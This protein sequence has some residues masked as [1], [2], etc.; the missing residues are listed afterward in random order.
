M[1]PEESNDL[2][3]IRKDKGLSLSDV[4]N[5]LK[6]T[7]DMIKKLE[8]SEFKTLG[9]YPYIRGY[10]INYTQLL[11]VES[12]KYISLIPKSE[13]VSPLI[14]TGSSLTKGIKLRRQSKNM[15]SYTIGTSIVL[16]ISFSGWYLL[17]NYMG[18]TR[19]LDNNI[20]LVSEKNIQITPQGSLGSKETNNDDSESFHYSSLIPSN[21]LKKE[22]N[23]DL[24]SSLTEEVVN[25]DE[26]DIPI[27]KV[28]TEDSV[29]QDNT[30]VNRSYEIQISAEETSW[31]K[32]EHLDGNKI[33]NDLFKP[34][35]M[36]FESDQPVHFRIGNRSKVQVTINGEAV[37]LSQYSSK[38]IADF[39]WPQDS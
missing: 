11:G 1:N 37:N 17:K 15:A 27:Q 31:V 28:V 26:I 38:N 30:V 5:K 2:K 7:S 39:K 16:I 4:A 12:E 10:L 22:I 33:H 9:A 25:A 8:N 34:G 35:Q 3:K 13:H 24:I 19:Q 23:T 32:I 29:D 21:D 36:K 20:E 18:Q 14:N 6:L